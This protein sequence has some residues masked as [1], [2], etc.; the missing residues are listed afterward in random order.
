MSVVATPG[1][2]KR[3]RLTVQPPEEIPLLELPRGSATLRLCQ[4]Q[5]HRSADPEGTLR[6][7][8]LT[9]ELR[10]KTYPPLRDGFPRPSSP[11]NMARASRSCVR[12]AELIEII[13]R[14]QSFLCVNT[15]KTTARASDCLWTCF[16]LHAGFL[17]PPK[18]VPNQAPR[19]LNPI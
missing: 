11:D 19:L 12:L 2:Q 15:K 17:A 4:G 10:K 7:A 16:N 8:D 3:Q 1:Q 9:M 14:C 18:A 13:H 6:Q 5:T